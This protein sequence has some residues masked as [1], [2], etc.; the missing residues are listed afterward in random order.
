[1]NKI[2]DFK[3][4]PSVVM[5]SNIPTNSLTSGNIWQDSA[6]DAARLTEKFIFQEEQSVQLSELLAGAYNDYER[7]SPNSGYVVTESSSDL[8]YF[9]HADKGA[10]GSQVLALRGTS[11]MCRWVGRKIYMWDLLDKSG[12]RTCQF[13]VPRFEIVSVGL[14]ESRDPVTPYWLVV[15]TLF[16][17]SLYYFDPNTVSSESPP[18]LSGYVAATGGALITS[19]SLPSSSKRIFLGGEDGSVFELIYSTSALKTTWTEYIL[20]S[21]TSVTRCYLSIL[22][23][24]LSC[25]L[26]SVICGVL[27]LN[28]GQVKRIEVD[29]WRGL[30]YVLGG[31]GTLQVFSLQENRLLA[32]LSEHQIRESFLRSNSSN[33]SFEVIDLIP[34]SPQ[35]GGIEIIALLVNRAG[36][37]IYVKA[38]RQLTEVQISVASVRSPPS[39][40]F[41]VTQ[42]MSP[43]NG[44]TI[45]LGSVGGGLALF[46]LDQSFVMSKGKLREILTVFAPP[47]AARRDEEELNKL[48][49]ITFFKDFCSP[50]GIE[51][52]SRSML[53]VSADPLIGSFASSWRIYTLSSEKEIVISPKSVSEQLV[54]IL[55]S[56]N[57]GAIRD[58]SVEWK[59]ENLSALLLQILSSSKNDEFDFD[60][61]QRILFS[62]ETASTLGLVDSP[63]LQFAPANMPIN[64]GPLGSA[65]QTQSSGISARSKGVSILLSRILRPVW[66][67]K[68]FSLQAMP[69]SPENN[70]FVVIK[71]NLSAPTRQRIE[72][73]VKPVLET[74]TRFR[75]ELSGQQWESKHIEGS[76]VLANAVGEAMELLRLFETGQ[77]NKRKEIASIDSQ[78]LISNLENLLFRDLVLGHPLVYELLNRQGIDLQIARKLCPLILHHSSI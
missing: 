57:L 26:P 75:H 71:S 69:S 48:V 78:E 19:I 38:N 1:M 18:A 28:K 72:S 4:V 67:V 36:A 31:V 70:L 21:S 56:K 50:L 40:D 39:V 61:A 13:S 59:P 60:T 37:R 45:A 43:D 35:V 42:A 9:P 11:F 68:V 33:N 53:P 12:S 76:I 10:V 74:L 8:L 41:Q 32:E 65:V 46:G 7:T 25:L 55:R 44:R 22:H 30:V 20:G 47:I 66:H 34:I 5:F 14:A 54:D 73:L 17:V 51:I 63:T 58:F 23:R 64:I 2:F 49:M 27:N 52:D 24:P 62:Y 16:D 3:Y 29:T 15:A 6:L 77:L